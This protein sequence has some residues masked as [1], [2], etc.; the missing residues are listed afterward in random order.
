MYQGSSALSLDSKG[1]M[2]IPSRYRTDLLTVESGR[3]TITR[4]LD[5]CLILYPRSIWEEK[6]EQIAALP[7]SARALQRLMLGSAQDVD[8]DSAGRILISPELRQAAGLQKNVMLLGLGAHFELWDEQQ[9]EQHQAAELAKG[10]PE[11]LE[12]FSL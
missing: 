10:L 9:L 7:M 3:L 12:H 1:R 6:R 4:H 8:I 2:I 5:G 11:S